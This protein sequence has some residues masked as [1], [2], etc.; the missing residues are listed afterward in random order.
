MLSDIKS[1]LQTLQRSVLTLPHSSFA[2]RQ[3]STG[4]EQL[5]YPDVNQ[6]TN[7]APTYFYLAKRDCQVQLRL[8]EC[9]GWPVWNL[10][11][12]EAQIILHDAVMTVTITAWPV[13]GTK[14]VQVPGRVS[15]QIHTSTGSSGIPNFL[16]WAQKRSG[17]GKRVTVPIAT[18]VPL[19]LDLCPCTLHSSPGSCSSVLPSSKLYCIPQAPLY[20]LRSQGASWIKTR[21]QETCQ[22]TAILA[23]VGGYEPYLPCVKSWFFMVHSA[24]SA[25]PFIFYFL[26]YLLLFLKPETNP[27]PAVVFSNSTCHRGTWLPRRTKALMPKPLAVLAFHPCPAAANICPFAVQERWLRGSYLWCL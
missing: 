6:S 2:C 13:V 14:P 10:G 21:E 18:F 17:R 5:I 7:I 19:L 8:Q 22:S 4:A 20:Q 27:G 3:P 23:Q 25:N 12:W 16:C 11:C 9:N 1:L 24:P 26:F 15:V